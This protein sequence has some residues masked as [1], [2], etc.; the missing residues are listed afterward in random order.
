MENKWTLMPWSTRIAITI[1]LI[2]L[3]IL[4]V[5]A[6]NNPE[7]PV[8]YTCNDWFN[9]YIYM[10]ENN[11]IEVERAA[12]RLREEWCYDA[13]LKVQ[14]NW[15]NEKSQASLITDEN[16]N[17]IWGIGNDV[18]T[19]PAPA[20]DA[21]TYTPIDDNLTDTKQ[22]PYRR[23]NSNWYSQRYVELYGDTK[24]E[25]IIS[26]FNAY[27]FDGEDMW[28]TIRTISRIYRVYPETIVCIAYADSSLGRFL[29]TQHNY[30]NVGNNDRGDTVSYSNVEQ[31]FNA[32]AKTLNNQYLW[33]YN[34]IDQLSRR[35]NVDGM[36]YATSPENWHINVTNCLGMIHNKYVPDNFNYRW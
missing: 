5:F 36:V 11:E 8:E 27:W 29:K 33:G 2:A 35:G 25:R 15:T 20:I 7:K 24:Q 31:G 10:V 16:W 17:F 28:Y 6:K 26:L 22:V 32:I 12:S 34:T 4:M 19:Q 18:N 3:F 21:N 13:A 1:M 30:G 9:N 23:L 14:Q